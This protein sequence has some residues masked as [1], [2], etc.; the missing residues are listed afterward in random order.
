MRQMGLRNIAYVPPE[1]SDGAAG[2]EPRE[3][4]ALMREDAEEWIEQ[5][6]LEENPRSGDFQERAKER[7]DRI[8][9]RMDAICWEEETEGEAEAIIKSAFEGADWVQMFD[10]RSYVAARCGDKAAHEEAAAEALLKRNEEAQNAIE[11]SSS[12]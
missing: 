12:S 4:C 8:F 10:V 1:S 9:Q 6:C 7:G 2:R 5:N 11:D 3:R